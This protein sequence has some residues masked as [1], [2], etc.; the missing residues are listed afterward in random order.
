MVMI[1]DTSNFPGL[2][3]KS[4]WLLDSSCQ[5]LDLREDGI[6]FLQRNFT[7][8]TQT[9]TRCISYGIM[10]SLTNPSI[11][12]THLKTLTCIPSGSDV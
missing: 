12:E 4:S 3:S 9:N 6:P 8:N 2:A 5:A 10:S 1:N 11:S 7:C